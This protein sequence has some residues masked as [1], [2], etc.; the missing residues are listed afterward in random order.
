MAGLSLTFQV[1]GESK[2]VGG[3][4]KFFFVTLIWW[5]GG[6]GAEVQVLAFLGNKTFL[7][8]HLFQCNCYTTPTYIT[9]SVLSI[10]G[11]DKTCSG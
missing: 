8:T 11:I 10:Y 3:D 6:V 4:K 9:T 5:G 1:G 2:K 7:K